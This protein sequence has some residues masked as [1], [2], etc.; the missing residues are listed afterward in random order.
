MQNIHVHRK[1]MGK[2]SHICQEV[3]M[4]VLESQ[5][6]E[7]FLSPI[8]QDKRY[9]HFFVCEMIW[10]HLCYSPMIEVFLGQLS[11]SLSRKSLLFYNVCIRH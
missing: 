5:K 8:G 4:V 2:Q 3:V 6:Q 7:L 10:W 1:P 11:V 9:N